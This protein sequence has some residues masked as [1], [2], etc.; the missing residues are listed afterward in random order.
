MRFRMVLVFAAGCACA[1]NGGVGCGPSGDRGAPG[2][3]AT[4]KVGLNG[5]VP[6]GSVARHTAAKK[7]EWRPAMPVGQG[8]ADAVEN[9]VG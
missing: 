2:L 6:R 9:Q 7:L 1:P 3:D 4:R 5:W 8:G